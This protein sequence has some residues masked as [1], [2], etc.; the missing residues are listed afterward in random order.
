MSEPEFPLFD[1]LTSWVVGTSN[2]RLYGVVWLTFHGL[3]FGAIIA[4]I[5]GSFWPLL[6]ASMGLCYK[7]AQDWERGELLYGATQGFT[8]FLAL[9]TSF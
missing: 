6:C 2:P 7:F 4:V 9:T 8:L 1:K 5:M 3:F